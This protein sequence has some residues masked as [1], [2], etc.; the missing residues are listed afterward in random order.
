MNV[1]VTVEGSVEAIVFPRWIQR[2][3][4]R[5]RPVYS[6]S[7]L[8]TDTF[9]LVSG[10]GYPQYLKVVAAAG[11]DVRSLGTVDRLVVSVDA[12]SM[13]VEQKRKQLQQA[14]GILP[15]SVELRL[16]VA[17]CCFESWALGNRRLCSRTVGEI[18][19]PELVEYRTQYDVRVRDPELMPS[20]HEK[21]WNRAQFAYRYLSLSVK[22]KGRIYSKQS[23]YYVA[24]HKYLDALERRIAET[25]EMSTFRDFLAAFS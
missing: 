20:L 5:L 9:Y 3:N 25:E 17:N 6:V 12:E 11:E 22:E 23:P 1:Y 10:R 16:V 18:H 21:R 4:P 19:S 7:L 24:E 14:V 2:L 15:P 8:T 13:T